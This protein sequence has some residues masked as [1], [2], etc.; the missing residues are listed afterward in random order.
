[1]ELNDFL[2]CKKVKCVKAHYNSLTVGK[3]YSVLNIRIGVEVIDDAGSKYY[4]RAN[5]FEPVLDSAENPLQGVELTPE[6]EAVEPV[7]SDNCQV[8]I[9]DIGTDIL[10]TNADIKDTPKFK[11]G[12]K[13]YLFGA[14]YIEEI[15]KIIGANFYLAGADFD[16]SVSIKEICHATTENYER[17]QAT[18][19]D[20]EFEQPPTQADIDNEAVDKL[21]Q[22]MKNK[23]AEKR[24]QGY[25]GW[26]T[27]K[28][29]DLVQLLINHV[30]KGDP[31]DVANF[32][33]FL[34]ARGE[35]LTESILD[36]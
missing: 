32:C 13:V 28:H 9:Q 27:C 16:A 15:T 18:F 30:D 23:L 5:H 12:D 36:E 2:K 11:V 24:E 35:P 26:E 4:W 10:D 34:F 22:A 31:I 6:F 19:P 25:H 20:I 3:E 33:A 29:G 7:L 1:M 21:A 17:L 14:D 8:N